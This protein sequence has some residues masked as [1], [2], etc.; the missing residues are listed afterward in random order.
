MNA[1]NVIDHPAVSWEKAKT[2][3]DLI[4]RKEG[5]LLTHWFEL[6]QI[7]NLLRKAYPA[8]QDFGA[9]CE[10]HGLD[11]PRQTRAAA[12]WWATL[13]ADQRDTLRSYYPTAMHPSTLQR[14]CYDAFPD[15][16]SSSRSG[17]R[18]ADT[19]Q[20]TPPLSSITPES[21][22]NPAETTATTADNDDIP[23]H[24]EDS[25]PSTTAAPRA[26]RSNISSP[27]VNLI[28]SQRAEIIMNHW[29]IETTRQS[30]N[31]L[32]KQKGAKPILKRIIEMIPAQSAPCLISA[33]RWANGSSSKSFSHR[34]FVS[35]LPKQWAR[36]YGAEWDNLGAIKVILNQVED[37]KRLY[38]E[39]GDTASMEECKAWWDNRNNPAKQPHPSHPVIMTGPNLDAFSTAMES[40]RLIEPA[41][42]AE[43][44][45]IKAHGTIIWPNAMAEY[46]FE[47]A[48]A[49]FHLW[50]DLSRHMA[51]LR[52]TGHEAQGRFLITMKSWL[53][54]ASPS[55]AKA[56]HKIAAAELNN[57]GQGADTFCPSRHFK[58]K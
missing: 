8:D 36:Y 11:L 26:Y 10:A 28:G 13:T 32:A 14:R 30:F 49:A 42:G 23:V 9:A 4:D 7:L 20:S 17:V 15:W 21:P 37:A 47:D 58:T 5:E 31:Y 48:W 16:L 55:F 6:G 1:S 51:G 53:D 38:A 12:M 19:G 39:L 54:Y 46:A 18:S 29:P 57:P 24:D 27:L 56:F 50:Q 33:G 22:S 34:L 2:V 44:E 3:F 52:D 45:T 25:P 43:T 35:R 40:K 41:I